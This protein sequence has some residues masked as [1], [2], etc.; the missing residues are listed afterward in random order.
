MSRV[1]LSKEQ[2][3]KH[4]FLKEI[5]I[6]VLVGILSIGTLITLFIIVGKNR[7]NDAISNPPSINW[8]EEDLEDIFMTKSV[9]V[10]EEHI[11]FEKEEIY[12]VVKANGL[13]FKV[14]Y[15]LVSRDFFVNW[16]WEYDRYIQI[17]EVLENDI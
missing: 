16:K 1:W 4:Q 5:V 8:I 6:I 10:Q 12:C 11:D 15:V 17:S 7:Y 14:H 3:E 9:D 2:E 13:Y